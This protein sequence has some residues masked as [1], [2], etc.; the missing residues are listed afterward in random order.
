[1]RASKIAEQESLFSEKLTNT[2]RVKYTDKGT[3]NIGDSVIR[4]V[5]PKHDSYYYKTETKKDMIVM[6]ST[7][8]TLRADMAS[9]TGKDN[10]V[11]VS[12]VIARSGEIYEVF[13]PKYWSYHLGR[14]AVGG[15]KVN[16]MRSIGIELSNYGPLVKKGDSLETIYSRMKYTDSNGKAKTSKKDVYCDLSEVNEYTVVEG[17]FRG[18][19]YF[20]SFT[21]EQY[22]ALSDLL[23]YLCKEHDIPKTFVDEDKRF[24]T[25]S[26]STEGK[27][28]KGICTH[29]NYRK[30]GKWDLGPDFNWDKLLGQEIEL[31]EVEVTPEDI[32]ASVED[33][34]TSDL[35]NVVDAGPAEISNVP[36]EIEDKPASKSNLFGVIFKLL[37]KLF[38]K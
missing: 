18:Y 23:D 13:D 17:G 24:D 36:T 5:R 1:M 31:E 2:S 7:V 32:A 22:A 10:R 15:N 4:K 12:Y 6:H 25:F 28:F 37:G 33:K 8:G 27:S 21:D 26:S 9:L 11:S 35:T 30:S 16:S 34:P 19:E 3:Q 20:A 14:G 38:G 29:V